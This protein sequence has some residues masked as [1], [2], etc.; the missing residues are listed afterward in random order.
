L[1]LNA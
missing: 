1:I